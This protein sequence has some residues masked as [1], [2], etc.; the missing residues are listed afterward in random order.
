MFSTPPSVK[1]IIAIT[2]TDNQT[3][4]GIG[5][6]FQWFNAA[7]YS[8]YPTFPLTV[9]YNDWNWPGSGGLNG[10]AL[11]TGLFSTDLSG[12]QFWYAADPAWSAQYGGPWYPDV[13]LDGGNAASV[14]DP[15]FTVTS[16][17]FPGNGRYHYLSG[18]AFY[19]DPIPYPCCRPIQPGIFVSGPIDS[20]TQDSTGF[21]G[22]SARFARN[23]FGYVP[24]TTFNGLKQWVTYIYYNDAQHTTGTTC[25]YDYFSGQRFSVSQITITEHPGVWPPPPTCQQSCQTSYNQCLSSCPPPGTPGNAHELCVQGCLTGYNGCLSQCH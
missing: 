10:G 13:M 25:A 9:F 19:P 14:G 15:S 23:E 12:G 1:R 22:D 5:Q 17:C 2:P 11:L 7:N 16:T 24:Y 8:G 18:V 20:T 6:E 4:A 3:G 21:R